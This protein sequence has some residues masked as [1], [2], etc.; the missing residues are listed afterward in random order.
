VKKLPH[1]SWRR[2]Y[3]NFTSS[4]LREKKNQ[5]K[6]GGS[7]RT[8]QGKKLTLDNRSFGIRMWFAWC[9]RK[10]ITWQTT[11][12]GGGGFGREIGGGWVAAGKKRCP[13]R[14][15]SGLLILYGGNER[16]GN[17]QKSKESRGGVGGMN[18]R[19]KLTT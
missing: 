15:E 7:L 13:T 1:Y 6:V 16:E 9:R 10:G 12:R 3:L 4:K 18:T 17:T 14:W 11:K 5:K 2:V 19:E 8:A